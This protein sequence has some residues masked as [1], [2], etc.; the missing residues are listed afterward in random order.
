VKHAALGKGHH[1]DAASN[2]CSHR[3]IGGS[4]G[5]SSRSRPFHWMLR[6][7]RPAHGHIDL[8]WNPRHQRKRTAVRARTHGRA[9][10]QGQWRSRARSKCHAP[11]VA[12]FAII[13]RVQQIP[14]AARCP[15]RDPSTGLATQLRRR[16]THQGRVRWN[17]HTRSKA[18]EPRCANPAMCVHSCAGRVDRVLVIRNRLVLWPTKSDRQQGRAISISLR[19]WISLKALP[20]RSFP[21]TTTD[22]PKPRRLFPRRSSLCSRQFPGRAQ[23]STS[24]SDVFARSTPSAPITNARASRSSKPPGTGTTAGRHKHAFTAAIK[25]GLLLRPAPF[26]PPARHNPTCTAQ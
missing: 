15:T 17:D 25:I 23:P 5:G 19:F 21:S 26:G 2:F 20:R 12:T 10:A 7:E 3:A 18:A 9:P 1:R 16:R 8:P 24:L 11:L 22:R 6:V 14:V 4:R 13:L